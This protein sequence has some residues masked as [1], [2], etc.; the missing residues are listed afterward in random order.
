MIAGLFLSRAVLIGLAGGVLG[1]LIGKL[2]AEQLGVR[3][4]DVAA[5]DFSPAGDVLL[6][7]LLGAP[8]ICALAAWLPTLR[9]IVQ[10]PAVVLRD[11]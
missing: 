5:Q 9:A 8:L 7:A 10:D 3:I 1:F 6:Y 4:F 11:A 2:L